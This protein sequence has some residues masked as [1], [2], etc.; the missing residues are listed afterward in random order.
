LQVLVQVMCTRGT[1]LREKIANDEH[2]DKHLMI[3]T[4]EKKP[5]RS[6]GWMKVHST[7]PE[8]A[9]AINV[10]WDARTHMLI[11]RV[12]TRGSGRPNLIVGD[13]I[14]YLLARHRSRIQ[15]INVIPR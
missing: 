3:V 8:R 1:S 14:D 4:R 5:G 2:A 15:S 10:E 6:K 12:V 7:E 11:C 9:G 13:F